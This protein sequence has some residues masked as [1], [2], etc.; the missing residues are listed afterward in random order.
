MLLWGV[1]SKRST[2]IGLGLQT[3]TSTDTAKILCSQDGK[4]TCNVMA[5]QPACRP[6][7]RH[8]SQ[9]AK[10]VP[11]FRPLRRERVPLSPGNGGQD[12][13]APGN[14]KINWAEFPA[15]RK[16]AGNSLDFGCQNARLQYGGQFRGEITQWE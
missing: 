3:L 7:D 16:F 8:K 4:Y 11:V 1:S 2:K 10:S 13:H 14:V 5:I 15:G 12:V 6:G 9:K